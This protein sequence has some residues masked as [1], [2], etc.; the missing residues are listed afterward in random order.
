MALQPL[1]PGRGKLQDLSPAIWAVIFSLLDSAQTV[2]RIASTCKKLHT[3]AQVQGWPCFVRSR[4]ATLKLP[5]GLDEKGWS[6][7]AKKLTSQSRAWGRG[8]FSITSVV[9]PV[10]SAM[11]SGRGQPD[12]RRG[13]GRSRGRGRGWGRGRGGGGHSRMQTFPAHIATDATTKRRRDGETWIPQTGVETGLRSGDDDVTAVSILPSISPKPWLLVGRA[14]V[15]LQL[16][17]TERNDVGRL[18]AWFHSMHMGIDQHDI[19]RVGVKDSQDAMVPTGAFSVRNLPNSQDFRFLREAKYMGSRDVVLCR[20][21]STEPLRFLTRTPSGT[22]MTNAAKLQ[23]SAR[24]TEPL[25]YNGRNPPNARS[26]LPVNTAS[27]IGGSGHTVLSSYDDGTVRLQDLRS[28][29]HI[30]A[31]FQDHFGMTAPLGPLLSY[32]MDGFIVGSTRLPI[33][34]IFD[35][36]WTRPYSYTDALDCSKTEL[37]LTPNTLT[38]IPT[39]K[40]PGYAK[41]YHL[42]RHQCTLHSLARTDFIDQIATYISPSA[43]WKK[44]R[45]GYAFHRSLA[46]L[47]GIGDEI[48]LRK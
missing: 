25:I 35:M 30:A 32:R 26:V 4:F 1:C 9:P 46:N 8:A 33:L 3:V 19:Q 39:P 22:A 38:G 28:H 42:L 11:D 5:N 7:L 37:G 29:S 6:D 20:A 40:A 2:A 18:I 36:R 14:N 31:I 27:L 13:R 43:D 34:N 45:W 16:T 24:C 10:Q 12:L 47:V 21:T 48:T 17:S 15:Y 23:P 41:C 44:N